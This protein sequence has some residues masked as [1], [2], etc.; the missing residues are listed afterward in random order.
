MD[1]PNLAKLSFCNGGQEK[2]APVHPDFLREHC[3]LSLM[4][5]AGRCLHR[6]RALGSAAAEAGFID[7]GL[8]C[9]AITA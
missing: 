1:A 9:F 5:C 8:T 2:I 3:S 6:L 7:H 4:G